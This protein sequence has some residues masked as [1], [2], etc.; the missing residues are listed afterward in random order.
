MAMV[1]D[2]LEPTYLVNFVEGLPVELCHDHGQVSCVVGLDVETAALG[3]SLLFRQ[4]RLSAGEGQRSE[5]YRR[6]AV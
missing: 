6:R 3:G 5:S 2:K 1:D 4:R